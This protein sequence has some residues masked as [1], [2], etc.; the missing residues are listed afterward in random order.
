MAE[1]IEVFEN[2]FRH[3][4]QSGGEIRIQ[5]NLFTKKFGDGE[6]EWPVQE[7]RYRLL[8]MPACPH[9]HKVVIT[10]RLL[11]LD[12][13][14]SLG[15][16]GIFRD[17]KGWVFTEDEGE[18]DSVLGI[19]YLKEIYDRD[20]PDGDYKERPT[21]PVIADTVTGKGVNNDHFWIP[22][23]FD[24]AWKPFHKAGAPDLY[25]EAFREEINELNHFIFERIN[26]GV[27]DVGFARSQEAYE[28]AY[29]RFFEALDI[30]E[31][32]LEDR[33]F[34]LGDY[35]TDSDIRL[36]PTLVRFDAVY[37]QVFH[38]NKKKLIDYKNLWAYARELYQ[39]S[40]I[41]ESTFFDIY[42]RHYQ[43]SPHLKPL[44]GNIYSIKAKGPDVSV[45]EEPVDREHLSA[46]PEEKFKK[47][48]SGY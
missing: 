28:K 4:I 27:Y 41:K 1:G 44:W 30:L 31:K 23:Y 19:H 17:P 9:A 34:L 12:K 15:T 10:R 20:C 6:G 26:N 22:I 21:V 8:W 32:R 2:T 47:E 37:F 38:A 46:D 29:H 3:Q 24:T 40:E 16:T 35:I 11:G 42:K 14:I 48:Q 25:P 36:Y 45:W 43:L 39:V 18:K 5:K 13:V 33:R 7:D